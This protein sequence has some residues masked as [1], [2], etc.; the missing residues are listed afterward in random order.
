MCAKLGE[1]APVRGK[2][3]APWAEYVTRVLCTSRAGSRSPRISIPPT[4][5][6]QQRRIEAK[7]RVWVSAVELPKEDHLCR[8]CGKKIRNERTNCAKCAVN[9]ATERV[10][11]AAR[12]GRVAGHTPAA[13]AKES[14]T[15][16]RQSPLVRENQGLGPCRL[17][18]ACSLNALMGEAVASGPIGTLRARRALWIVHTFFVRAS[19]NPLSDDSGARCVRLEEA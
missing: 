5:L 1:T 4:R 9:G 17:W 11:D 2:P 16:R 19:D 15:Q 13:L 10:I 18:L 8:G 14:H 6:T 12:S 3:V 7:G